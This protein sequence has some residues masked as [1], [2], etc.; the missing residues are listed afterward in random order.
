MRQLKPIADHCLPG[1]FAYEAR[2]QRVAKSGTSPHLEPTTHTSR[3]ATICS[4]CS[5][6]DVGAL[7]DKRFNTNSCAV[8]T[9]LANK[10]CGQRRC[11][12][13]ERR[14]P[15]GSTLKERCVVT[16]GGWREVAF[17]SRGSRHSIASFANTFVGTQ[18][19]FSR[20]RPCERLWSR[21][22]RHNGSNNSTSR[23]T[24]RE[25]VC[26]LNT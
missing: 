16:M 21:F 8:G 22:L 11:S 19:L 12:A 6:S 5:S 9:C 20:N 1:V 10:T 2:A 25:F 23:S 13:F 14:G 7:K 26:L 3:A 15:F 24:V 4:F 18:K 17:P